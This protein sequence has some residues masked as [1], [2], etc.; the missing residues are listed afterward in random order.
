MTCRW[1]CVVLVLVLAACQ[2]PQKKVS[3]Y[4]LDDDEAGQA[5]HLNA[6]S[7]VGDTVTGRINLPEYADTETATNSTAA[8]TPAPALLPVHTNESA[9]VDPS[10]SQSNDVAGLPTGPRCAIAGRTA[11]LAP[12][13][14]R[15][16]GTGSGA[17]HFT[18][19]S[20]LP[21]EPPTQSPPIHL[22]PG[23]PV[24][25][26][27]HSNATARLAVPGHTMR[28]GGAP[29][30]QP[31][32]LSLPALTN[33]AARLP[34]S[35]TNQNLGRPLPPSA[36]RQSAISLNVSVNRAGN[37]VVMTNAVHTVALPGFDT[38]APSGAESLSQPVNLAPLLDGGHDEAWRQRQAD[39]QRAAESARQS[40][41]D[42][43][44]K[45]LQQFLQPRAK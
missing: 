34:V 25:A 40:E 12:G 18:I 37:S 20:K 13:G 10:Q 32:H 38:T 23:E 4:S 41:R 39:Q 8:T 2:T 1:S 31:I 21:V 26:A 27:L 9:V 33:S 45:T 35:L 16:A 42:S 30:S 36:E 24:P 6:G 5:R 19:G 14:R 15:T 17:E 44:E 22:Q 7:D 11:D 43:L 28:Q 3:V 29:V